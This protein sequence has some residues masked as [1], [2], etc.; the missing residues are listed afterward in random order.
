MSSALERLKEKLTTVIDLNGACAVLGWDQHTYMPKGGITARARQLT[1]LS[2]LSHE[3]FTAPEIGTLLIE[4]ESQAGQAPEDENAA[5]LR[6]IRRNYDQSVKL[7][8]AFVQEMSDAT[9]MSFDAWARCKPADDFEGF[10][11]HLEKMVELSRREAEYLG[12]PEQPY[13]ALLNKYE[14]GMLTSQVASIFAE[15]RDELLPFCQRLFARVDQVEDGFFFTHWDRDR[16]WQLTMQV[17]EEIGYDFNR[18]RQDESPHPFTT[19]FGIP[20]VRVTTR[21]HTDQFKAGLYG[22]IHEGGH[23]LYEQNVD[24][25]Y[26]RTM[27]AGGTSLGIHE[28][29]SRL[30]E[31]LIGRSRDFCNYWY[32]VV[33]ALFPKNME[34]VSKE[35]Y[36][37]AINRVE[38]SLIRIEADEVTYS[39]HIFLRFE[40]ELE[41]ISGTLKVKD[42]PA[43]WDER[44]EKYLGIRP[45]RVSRGC[46]QDMHWSDASFGYFPTYA[47]GNL[48]GVSI[49]NTLRE[50]QPGILDGVAQGQFLPL[51]DWLTDQVYRHGSRYTASELIQRI[52]GRALEAAPFVSYIKSKYSGIYDL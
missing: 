14:P 21:I 12:Y 37:R 30:W 17:L 47:L 5:M 4:A 33:K 11:P 15:V 49:L 38:P 46:M 42:L 13:D 9:S 19:D 32:P 24:P 39:L 8:A 22:T 2:R 29:Q 7:P 31:N 45:D 10:R 16:Q 44:M 35:Q 20:D 40:L 34:G 26:D 1:T 3:A 18:G 6:A 43:A 52:T 36:Y 48:Y 28:S 25:R 41:L 51:R 50:Q 27:L 23:A